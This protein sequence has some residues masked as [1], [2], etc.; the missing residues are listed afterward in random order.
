[1]AAVEDYGKGMHDYADTIVAQNKASQAMLKSAGDAGDA[2]LKLVTAE[3]VIA[4][5]KEVA[6]SGKVGDGKIFILPMEEAIRI[7]T[8]ESGVSAI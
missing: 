7:R 3:K 4:T 6:N 1:M 2:A 8:G 5:I